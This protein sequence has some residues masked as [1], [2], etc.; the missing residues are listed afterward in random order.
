MPVMMES[1]NNVPMQMGHYVP[2]AGEI[3]FIGMKQFTQH[4][5]HTQHNAHDVLLLCGI[6]ITH[7]FDVGEPNNPA[8]HG[9][10]G[11]FSQNYP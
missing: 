6:Q 7:F 1:W 11:F 2:Q 9:V 5:L 8:Q 4:A 3:D 10:I